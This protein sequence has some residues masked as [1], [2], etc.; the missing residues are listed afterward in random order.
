MTLKDGELHPVSPP[1]QR[2]SAATQVD[3][4]FWRLAQA[5]AGAVSPSD[6]ALAMAELGAGAAGAALSNMALLDQGGGRI[7]V[8][9]NSTVEE[10]IADRWSDFDLTIDTP[11]GDAITSM[12]PVLL[13]SL[14]AI[15]DRYPDLLED[16]IAAGLTATASW[17]LRRARGD[18]LGAV[19]FGWREPQAFDPE[20]C[21]V[22]SLIADLTAQALDRALLYGEQVESAT[23]ERQVG[24]ELRRNLD[25]IQALQRV[26]S[27]LASATTPEMICRV[28]VDEGLT[29]IG[30]Y[31]GVCVADPDNDQM[32]MGWFT[33]GFSRELDEIFSLPLDTP[34]GLI[35]A[36]RTNSLVI[37]RSL[38]ESIALS[39]ANTGAHREHQTQGILGVPAHANG[40]AV[41]AIGMG[42]ISEGAVTE[43]VIAISRTLADL[44][45]QA[46]YRASLYERSHSAARALQDSLLPQ[47]PDVP[48]FEL[49]ARY[50]PGGAVGGDGEVVVGGDWYEVIE[51]EDRRLGIV[52]GDVMG[53]GIGAAAVMGQL[54]AL[55]RGYGQLELPPGRIMELLSSLLT[56]IAEGQIATC[57]YAV[58]DQNTATLT[59]ASAGHLMPLLTVPGS[60]PLSLAGPIGPPL[61]T[62]VHHYADHVIDVPAGSLLAL[63]TDGLIEARNLDIDSGVRH[64]SDCLAEHRNSPLFELAECVLAHMANFRKADD[65]T[66][67]LLVRVP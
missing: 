22:L 36:F 44:M 55:A 56:T 58:Y 46:F 62:K 42:F 67:L 52:I 59:F 31:G 18:S 60:P 1:E 17:P 30:D 10:A 66:A 13:P 41:G 9:H 53:R 43:E 16:S 6:I 50:A 35:T 5:L 51:L 32:V 21:R 45:G 34:M 63:F 40:V 23:Y 3:G 38:D 28:V 4:A 12:A 19:G 61:G 54:R 11:L 7:R 26:T 15:G 20:Q 37:A 57:F 47:L 8:F 27:K 48:G 39:P 2:V 29:M 33:P 25:R 24:L 65:D 49:A 64:L 14:G